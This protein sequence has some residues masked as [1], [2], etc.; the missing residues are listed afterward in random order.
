MVS[1]EKRFGWGH[2]LASAVSTRMRQSLRE[3]EPE[4]TLEL[5]LEL[6]LVYLRRRV[7]ARLR[8]HASRCARLRISGATISIASNAP[9]PRCTL[10]VTRVRFHRETN[11]SKKST[12]I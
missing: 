12:I 1:F 11:G 5:E 10:I 4:L 3:P 8:G 6:D 2:Y 7:A 9:M